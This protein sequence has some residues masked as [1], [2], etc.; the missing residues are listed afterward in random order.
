MSATTIVDYTVY[1]THTTLTPVRGEPSF[2]S[3][4]K[5][6]NQIHENAANVPYPSLANGDTGHLGL[7]MNATDF[8]H[9]SLN[10][11]YTR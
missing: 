8:A 11:A 6:E 5:L 3:L 10:H 1:I 7:T 2:D 9:V 4:S